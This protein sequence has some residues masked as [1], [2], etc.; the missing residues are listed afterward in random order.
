MKRIALYFGMVA[1]LVAACSI[2]E[3]DFMTPV[4]DDEIFYASFEQPTEDGTRVYANEDLLLRWTADDRVSIFN[5]ITYNQQYRFIGET[6]DYE[7]GFNKVDDPEF[8]TGQAIPHVIS[9]YPFQRQTRVSE[10]EI[11]TVSLPEDQYYAP[12][13]FGLGANTMVSVSSGNL[14]Q[15]KTVGG[16]LVV[17]LYGEGLSVNSITL[18]GNSGEII[19]GDATVTMPL[20]GTPTVTMANN[21]GTEIILNCVTPV[22]L[23]ASEE[24]SVPFWFVVPPVTFH[25][26]FTI[27]I[28]FYG[29]LI[30]EKS[31]TK[32]VVVNRNKLI[33]MTPTLIEFDSSTVVFSGT[34]VD[35]NDDNG[36][37]SK[38]YILNEGAFPGA[39]TLDLLDLKN[40]KYCTD[41]F[42]QAN[43]EVA[44]GLGNAA[45]DLIVAD[46]KMWV[47]LNASNQVA[48]LHMPDAKLVKVIE[49]ESP[50][51]LV[52]DGGYVY[53]SS[54]GA[55]VY[56]GTDMIAGKVYRIDKKSY[57]T[58]TVEVGYQP[59]GLAVLSGKLYVANSGGYNW[60]H[61]NRISVIDIA[62]FKLDKH[63][64][65]PMTN[66]YQVVATADRIWVSSYGESIWY[67]DADGNWL[68][69]V[70]VPQG[71][72]S[73]TPNGQF[74]EWDG[75][76]AAKMSL[77]G[78]TLVCFG[79]DAELTGGYD[80][81]VYF[82]NTKGTNYQK[83]RFADSDLKCIGYPYAI[84]MNPSNNDL[85]I[86]D[87]NFT[88]GSKLHC[89]DKNLKYK[90]TVN[91]GVATG[92][93]VLQ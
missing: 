31:T 7:G 64:E 8:M 87:A 68:S 13:T 24:D 10:D 38:L 65:A 58:K 5:K 17:N 42:A 26:G 50:R 80:I 89:F 43:P 11:I 59:E 83:T 19:A 78:N 56:G 45:N 37:F 73:M 53:V 81:C 77:S 88:G 47:A 85:Y 91:T 1:A 23:G 32:K 27:T 29:G 90:W 25:E 4:Q 34:D 20:D 15:Y 44:Q 52:A 35:I 69:S 74:T 2:Q 79:N 16:F 22:K 40:N 21:S 72:V 33:K 49:V 71:L 57:E 51:Y 62:S 70:S 60:V 82:V 61:D 92:S 67:Q 30:F 86:A 75:V 55:A 3:E 28:K 12:N 6:G 41:I 66:L 9:V 93:L 54:Y 48:V 84:L 46:D 18:K 36:D 39:S 14:L 63:I 76:H